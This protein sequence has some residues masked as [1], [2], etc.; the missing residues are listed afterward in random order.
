MHFEAS[1]NVVTLGFK[2]KRS[3]AEVAKKA[4]NTGTGPFKSHVFWE[5]IGHE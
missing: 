1:P 5:N 4:R 3:N 2:N